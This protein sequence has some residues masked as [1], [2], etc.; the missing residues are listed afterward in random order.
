MQRLLLRCGRNSVLAA[1]AF[2][3]RARVRARWMRR[4]PGIRKGLGSS[5]AFPTNHVARP[6]RLNDGAKP[7]LCARV[8]IEVVCEGEGDVS[9]PPPS[10]P[11]RWRGGV[12]WTAEQQIGRKRDGKAFVSFMSGFESRAAFNAVSSP[13]PSAPRCPLA[14]APYPSPAPPRLPVEPRLF[15]RFRPVLGLF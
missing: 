8:G 14:P 7:S 13:P 15:G 12:D 6:V 10:A 11:R 2:S 4:Q 9:S 1:A 3:A 5:P